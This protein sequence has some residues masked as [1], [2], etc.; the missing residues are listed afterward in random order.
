MKNNYI[1]P[2]KPKKFIRF[3]PNFFKIYTFNAG[4]KKY[5]K[6]LLV[7]CFEKPVYCSCVFTKSFTPAA[8]IIW[9]KNNNKNLCKV[10][11]V[12]SGNANAFTGQ[13]GIKNIDDYVKF[14]SNYF[15]CKTDQIFVSSTGVIGEQINKNLILDKIK[16]I[17]N[18]KTG[19]ILDAAKAIMTTD[20]F[21]KISKEDIIIQNKRYKI[22]GIAK[23]S[24][25]ISPNMG[26]MLAYIF[27]DLP[28]NKNEIKQLLSKNIDDTFNSITVDGDTSTNDT[29]MLFSQKNEKKINITNKLRTQLNEKIKKVMSSLAKQIVLDGEGI[30]KMIEVNVLNAKT[31]K[32]AKNI[33]FSIANSL[34][35]K[36][37]I[38]GKDANWGRVVMAIGKTEEKIVQ[39][40][41]V[42]RFGN[43]IVAKNGM[44]NKKINLKNLDKYMKRRKIVINVELNIGTKKHTVFS[45]DLSNKYIEINADYRS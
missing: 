32:Q 23:G 3:K 21:P 31:K 10:L 16:L 36:T 1:S 22:Y 24:G 15:G 38:H 5:K 4:F 19:N 17:N 14:T 30:T 26:T 9:S 6:D 45:S 2:F 42:L 12:N 44:M 40:K 33:A 27:M 29:V 25:M 37:A 28:L 8:P 7:I 39:E 11:I 18:S 34:L 20:T 43:L 41:I 13:K 35:V